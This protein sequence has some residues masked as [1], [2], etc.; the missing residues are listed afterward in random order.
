VIGFG[1][2][3][4]GQ[5]GLGDTED[6]KRPTEIAALAG[7]SCHVL[8]AGKFHSALLNEKNKLYMWG[9][10]KYG[11]LGLGVVD[12]QVL[13]PQVVN[14]EMLIEEAEKNLD[15]SGSKLYIRL[16]GRYVRGPDGKWNG[17]SNE[18]RY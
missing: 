9:K 12:K 13:E 11:Q 1:R 15:Y 14:A 10:N 2:N 17:L 4:H 18:S 5:L 6:R 8:E 7:E 16:M 3:N